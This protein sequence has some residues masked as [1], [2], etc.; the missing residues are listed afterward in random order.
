MPSPV[1]LD[2]IKK[3]I[4]TD[5]VT[6]FLSFSL[7]LLSCSWDLRRDISPDFSQE[8][9]SNSSKLFLKLEFSK[10]RSLYLFLISL[11]YPPKIDGYFLA[12][13]L[14]RRKKKHF[15]RSGPGTSDPSPL[16]YCGSFWQ[17]QVLFGLFL[18]GFWGIIKHLRFS[19]TFA[20]RGGRVRPLGILLT[21]PQ[22]VDVFTPS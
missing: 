22:K 12:D 4:Y 7:P 15:L 1:S 2:H 5:V 17:N 10:N 11:K 6:W 14:R 18:S 20:D 21:C 19:S 16:D 3:I 8:L 13:T 9:H